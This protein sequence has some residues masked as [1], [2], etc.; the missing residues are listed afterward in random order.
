MAHGGIVNRV[1]VD[2]VYRQAITSKNPRVI[3]D[4]AKVFRNLGEAEKAIYL[5]GRA[6]SLDKFECAFGADTAAIQARLN[7]LGANLTVD[8][9]SGPNTLAA[10]QAFQSSHGITPDGIVGPITLAAL[11]MTGSETAPVATTSGSGIIAVKGLETKS[12]AFKNKLVQVSNALGVNPDWIAS[13]MSFETGGTFSPSVQNPY[14]KATGLIQFMSSTAKSLGTTLEDLK[15]MSDVEQLD[16]VYRYFL[17]FKGRMRSLDDTYLA[18]FMP[19]QIGKSSDS[20]VAS[21][22]SAVY[23][24]NAGFDR[25]QKGYFT[26]GDITGAIRGVYNAGV[27]RGRIPVGVAIAAGG[28]GLALLGFGLGAWYLW[29]KRKKG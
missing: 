14:S 17:P 9:V 16:W 11:G 18:V 5:E 8:G 1:S 21:E 27:A 13:I 2:E 6:Y 24:Q 26:V 3:L 10:I 23:T 12:D 28:G 20:V 19:T 25:E 7:A 29:K 15:V 4:V 22:G